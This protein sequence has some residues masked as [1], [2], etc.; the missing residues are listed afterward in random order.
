MPSKKQKARRKLQANAR[1]GANRSSNFGYRLSGG[2]HAADLK[3]DVWIVAG[4]PK[5]VN[6]D[7]HWNMQ[8]RFGIAK[9]GIHDLPNKCW[10]SHPAITE[11]E[12]DGKR[13]LTEFEKDVE[14]LINKFDLFARLKGLDWRNRIGRYAG[15]IP[16]VRESVAEGAKLDATKPSTQIGGIEALIKLVPVPESQISVDNVN[17]NSDLSSEDY[18]MPTHYNFRQNVSGDRNPI[19]NSEI[20]LDPTRLFVFAEGADDGSIFGIPANEAGF[21]ALMD[22]EKICAAG[23]EGLFKNA[24]QRTVVNVNNDQVANLITNDKDAA[25]AWEQASDDFASG[26]NTMLT[27][28]GMDLHSLQSTLADPTQPFTNSLNVYA[29]SINEPASEIVGVQMNKQA[30]VGNATAFADTAESRNENTL[31]PMI[32]AFL[33][34]L[35]KRGIIKPAKD[36]IVV[37]WDSLSE[38]TTSE[39]LDNSKKMAE[40]NKLGRESGMQDLAFAEEEIREGIVFEEKPKVEGLEMFGEDDDLKDDDKSTD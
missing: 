1:S 34:Y 24:K 33:N 20:Q 17:T 37:T 31:S 19:E 38:P 3:R 7:M 23:S 22:L 12:F 25:E 36:K 15:I 5:I 35:I 26:F 10:Q 8:A 11:G 6:F 2:Y 9:A 4:Y 14:I 39:K 16:I 21:N 13:S 18:G 30:S 29:A 28:F 40:V 32:I 27:T